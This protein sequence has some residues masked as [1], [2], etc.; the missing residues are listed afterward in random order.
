MK[1]RTPSLLFAALLCGAVGIPLFASPNATASNTTNLLAIDEKESPAQRP[2][3]FVRT[4][5]STNTV[6]LSVTVNYYLHRSM[7]Q[8]MQVRINA[9]RSC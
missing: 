5:Q 1:I 7:S 4:T 8:T 2:N 3:L 9:T 6:S